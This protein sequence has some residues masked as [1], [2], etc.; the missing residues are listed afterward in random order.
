MHQFL[1]TRCQT[2]RKK[3]VKDCKKITSE[4]K[5]NLACTDRAQRGSTTTTRRLRGDNV[6]NKG[7]HR[8]AWGGCLPAGGWPAFSRAVS[9]APGLDSCCTIV[10]KFCKQKWES[11]EVYSPPTSLFL[12]SNGGRT[13]PQEARSR[14]HTPVVA[15]S[16]RSLLLSSQSSETERVDEKP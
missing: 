7:I 12:Y 16:L 9:F 13:S 2:M 10:L 3:R 14:T 4:P 15:F 8:A 1:A 11:T 5:R 6:K